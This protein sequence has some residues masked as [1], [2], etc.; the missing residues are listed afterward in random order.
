M[1]SD[2]E[3]SFNEDIQ[4]YDPCTTCMQVILDA[5][6]G[7]NYDEDENQGEIPLLDTEFD[8]DTYGST[9]PL[10]GSFAFVSDYAFV[11]DDYD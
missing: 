8:D 7:K 10:Q 5:A 1:M 6:Y 4:T 3:T 9:T 11:S 2:N